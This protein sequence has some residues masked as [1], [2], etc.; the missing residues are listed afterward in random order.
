MNAARPV[1]P[2]EK[3]VCL[4]SLWGNLWAGRA[5]IALAFCLLGS[6]S[7]CR[8]CPQEL[9]TCGTPTFPQV[10]R[11]PTDVGAGLWRMAPPGCRSLVAGSSL[12]VRWAQ[13][14][15]YETPAEEVGFES[16][17]LRSEEHDMGR[18][19]GGRDKFLYELRS[20]R[21]KSVESCL[22][23]LV[24]EQFGVC[25]A[26]AGRV[27]EE[28]R[29]YMGRRGAS[30]RDAL[31][32]YVSLPVGRALRYKISPAH[33]RCCDVLVTP[34]S[35]DDLEVWEQQDIRAMQTSR[36]VRMVEQAD[37]AGATMPLSRLTSLV[38]LTTRT[39][40]A[41]LRPLW[42]HGLHLPVLGIPNS[43]RAGLSRLAFVLLRHVQGRA[44]DDV[45]RELLLGPAGHHELLRKA[46]AFVKGYMSGLTGPELA[47]LLELSPVELES[48]REV[49]RVSDGSRPERER[50]R[51]LAARD[52]GLLEDA[53]TRP[54]AEEPS[55]DRF[56]SYLMRR[57]SFS[58]ARAELLADAVERVAD[59]RGGGEGRGPGEV[60]YWAV[61][62]QEPA[63]KALKDCEMIAASLPYYVPEEDLVPRGTVGNDLKM[64]KV[65]R[66]AS[67]A[68]TQGA[69]LTLP[70]LAF[71]LGMSVPTIQHAAGKSAVIVPTRGN[72]KDIG[73]GLTHRA[74]IVRLYVEGYSEADIVR[75]TG[76]SYE[77][78]GSY[79]RDFRRVMAL[80]DRGLPAA[81]IRKVT[82]MSRKLVEAYLA[83]YQEVDVPDNQWKLNLMRRAALTEQKKTNRRFP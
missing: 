53:L 12:K 33:A 75:R 56:L 71:L 64:R 22:R 51:A 17:R 78:V 35:A 25:E 15:L 38:H 23:H 81:H 52:M 66:L 19:R 16:T 1:D 54:D 40:S 13:L 50:L 82:R 72:M 59:E 77:S 20:V 27:A 7:S 5:Q 31:D 21:H 26:E 14:E 63:G 57:H 76:H 44:V 68:R 58:P 42:E 73:R 45:R 65:L 8:G 80:A 55:R 2:V 49:I 34:V 24:R 28:C 43:S 9:S 36:L 11:S 48:I 30:V 46:G 74:E 10:H 39:I 3:W 60:V 32:I 29:E 79:V 61:S 4:W 83:L 62:A 70:D 6:A 67:H 47:E 18:G 69:L 37:R 41:R